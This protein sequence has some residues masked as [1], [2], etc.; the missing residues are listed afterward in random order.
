[1]L[2]AAAPDCEG[3]ILHMTQPSPTDDALLVLFANG[4]KRAARELMDRLSPRAF[5]V[6]MRVLGNAA[7]AEDVTQDAMMRLW[8]VAPDWVPGQAKVSTWLYRVV[9]NLCLDIKRRARSGNVGLDQ[10]PEP[11]DGAQSAADQ[12]QDASRWDA[13][14]TALMALP[15]RQRQ[16]VVLRHL[17]ELANPEIATVMEISVEAVESLIARGK[18]ALAAALQGQKEELGYANG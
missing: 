16:A 5:S 18:R 6:A 1:M 13:L 11:E 17:E 8:K 10:V 14:Q 3:H 7:E 9:M 4:D 2:Y 12:M 15:E